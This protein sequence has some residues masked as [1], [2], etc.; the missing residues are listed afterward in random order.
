V[1][2]LQIQWYPGHM[3]KG[4]KILLEQLKLVDVVIEI[5][6]ARIPYSSANPD[7]HQMVKN[8][9]R[10][11]ILNKADLADPIQTKQ[12]I[13]YFKTKG[14]KA[15]GFDSKAQKG[16]EPLIKTI[17]S[18]A[19][20]KMP[21]KKNFLPRPIRAMI[22][23]IPNVG[24]STF[25]NSLVRKKITKTGNKPGVTKGKQWIRVL[26]DLELLDTPG[27]LWP[28][29]ESKEVGFHLAVTGAISDLVFDLVEVSLRLLEELKIN[30][31][32]ILLEKYKFQGVDVA[33]IELLEELGQKRGFLQTGGLI[34][35]EKTAIALLRDFRNGKLGKIS[36]EKPSEQA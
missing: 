21:P 19:K 18:Y 3:A 26:A 28:K 4:K 14:I 9:P 16:I 33:E 34:D 31:P 5:L 8:K 30:Y 2:D 24:K 11:I 12:W 6:D 29:F 17:V 25:I 1:N 7:F 22:V 15:L 35:M 10:I 32:N 13:K 23:G 20:S 27:L 36:L